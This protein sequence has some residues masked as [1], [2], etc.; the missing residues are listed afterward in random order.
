MADAGHVTE[1]GDEPPRSAIPTGPPARP[2]WVKITAIVVLVLILL[3]GAKFAIG[4]GS[5]G[6]GRHGGGD[7]N[8]SQMPPASVTDGGS[9]G[10]TPPP[11]GHGP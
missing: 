3:V 4:G 9:G 7:G 8:G 11:G 10:H 1:T 5:H 2:R 6:P